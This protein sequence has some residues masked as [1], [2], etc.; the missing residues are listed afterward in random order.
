MNMVSRF[1][2]TLALVMSGATSYA[3][4]TASAAQ[5]VLRLSHV[6]STTSS[7]H[8]AALKMASSV[9]ELTKGSLRIDVYPNS[10]LGN[11]AKSI[12][13]VKNG[14]LDITLSLIHI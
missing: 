9:S 14:T 6:G 10:E 3:Q 12:A 11:D 13:D 1:A 7:Q 8:L 4:T 2:L 5:T